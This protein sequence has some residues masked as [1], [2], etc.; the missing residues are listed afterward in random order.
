MRNVFDDAGYREIRQSLTLSIRTRNPRGLRRSSRM[1]HNLR[2]RGTYEIE[3]LDD[4]SRL[5]P[6]R[7]SARPGTGQPTD[8]SHSSCDG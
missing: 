1:K 8:L 7:R 3:I 6:G 2:Q 5:P 4:G